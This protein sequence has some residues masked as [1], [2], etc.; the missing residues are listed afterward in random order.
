LPTVSRFSA[1]TDTPEVSPDRMTDI[2]DDQRPWGWFRRY[3]L[4]QI[5]TVKIISVD[6]GQ[7][8]SEQ[9]HRDREE[10][11][12]AL[13]DGLR[14]Q[15]DGVTTD[16]A[17]GDEF[18]VPSGAIHRMSCIGQ[19]PCR[20]LEIAFGIFDEDDIERLSDDYGRLGD[21]A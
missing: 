14:V 13:D 2:V 8:L 15:I 5:S 20:V 21:D 10:L 12:V 3:T 9:R 11:W 16:A 7:N 1:M 18:F 17:V 19:S 6:P 4:N